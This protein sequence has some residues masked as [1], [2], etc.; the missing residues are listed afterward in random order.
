MK[1]L[2]KVNYSEEI[3]MYIIIYNLHAINAIP[4]F[5]SKYKHKYYIQVLREHKQMFTFSSSFEII[6]N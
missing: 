4:I 5:T 1:D 3:Y 6:C 2:V